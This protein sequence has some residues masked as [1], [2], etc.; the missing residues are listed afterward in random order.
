VTL[1]IRRTNIFLSGTDRAGL[2]EAIAAGPDAIT[3]F[4]DPAVTPDASEAARLIERAA[5]SGA[6]VFVGVFGALPEPEIAGHPRI[7]GVA[8]A[9]VSSADQI[10]QAAQLLTRVD[11]TVGSGGQPLEI[12]A[13]LQTPKS[14]WN[15]RQIIN[16]SRRV[17]QVV[18]DEAALLAA[19]DI[20]PGSPADALQFAIGR[21]VIESIAAGREPIAFPCPSSRA[22]YGSA[23]HF[24]DAARTL[25]NLGFKGMAVRDSAGTAPLTEGFSPSTADVEHASAV[26][27]TFSAA[28]A[29]GRAA[30]GMGGQMID[31]PV[32][33]RAN[34]MLELAAA[35]HARD[36]RRRKHDGTSS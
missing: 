3:I 28:A 1:L 25:R 9:G 23:D 29:Q 17:R 26:V 5:A 24:L 6:D 20:V 35:C 31:I 22:G 12:L 8:L 34:A 16:A 27:N 36:A 33:R 21:V 7:T 13:V 11:T 19:L 15:C 14:V 18:C 10:H 2:E 4:F 30:V 32:A